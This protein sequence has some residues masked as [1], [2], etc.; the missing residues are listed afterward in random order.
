MFS[1]WVVESPIYYTGIGF[2]MEP[3]K[4]DP[5]GH[6]PLFKYKTT[7]LAYQSKDTVPAFCE[8]LNV[9]VYHPNNMQCAQNLQMDFIYNCSLFTAE[10]SDHHSTCSLSDSA[11]TGSL[12]HCLLLAESFHQVTEF[13][14]IPKAACRSPSWLN[15]EW[16]RSAPPLMRHHMVCQKIFRATSQSVFTV[17]L[18]PVSNFKRPQKSPM[19]ILPL[20]LPYSSWQLP[21]PQVSITGS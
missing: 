20:E 3:E 7:I 14:N 12:K 13:H 16:T 18:W 5:Q 15:T 10:A 11:Q 2:P 17:A 4:Y 21:S 1:R 8:S 19:Q 9:H 6:L